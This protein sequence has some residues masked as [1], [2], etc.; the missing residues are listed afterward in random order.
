MLLGCGDGAAS[1]LTI[2]LTLLHRHS[3]SPL[4]AWRAISGQWP[5]IHRNVATPLRWCGNVNQAWGSANIQCAKGSLIKSLRQ[6]RRFCTRC[7]CFDLALNPPVVPPQPAIQP[8]VAAQPQVV[9][10]DS[11][12]EPS[13]TS[14]HGVDT[15]LKHL[16]VMCKLSACPGASIHKFVKTS[17]VAKLSNYFPGALNARCAH[18]L[19]PTPNTMPCS[20]GSIHVFPLTLI[21]ILMALTNVHILATHN[22][23]TGNNVQHKSG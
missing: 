14:V 19:M 18:A 10:L 17:H 4:V 6:M 15:I 16:G 2:Q 13:T 8:S 1:R 11:R 5:S 23:Q 9:I 22:Q 20:R 12:A 21:G 7:S 3:R